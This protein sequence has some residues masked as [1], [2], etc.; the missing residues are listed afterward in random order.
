MDAPTEP[1]DPKDPAGDRRQA[2][3]IIFLN[4]TSS[5]GTT[6]LACALQAAL[7]EPYV[8]TWPDHLLE[9]VPRRL[10]VSFDPGGPAAAPP[11]E[12]WL[13]PFAD[14]ALVG[15]PRIGPVGLQLLAGMYRA[16]AAL[17]AAGVNVIVDDVIYD[18]RVLRA[19]ADA[20]ADLSV[21][22]VGVCCPL[23]VAEAR[24]RMRGDR[25]PGGARVFHG[26]V[27]MLVR[28]YGH[29]DLEVDTSTGDPSACAER[30][31]QA[32]QTDPRGT[33]LR[34]IHERLLGQ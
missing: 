19:A 16:I 32:L 22:F 26:A 9:R 10:R 11:A 5:S 12:G 15:A 31:R 3:Q 27:H 7:D 14:G 4:G 1:A 28:T 24:E 2:G 17:A 23:V 21:L 6:S 34:V 20:L 13:L 30:V 33:G 29:Y 8:H 25:A 18:R